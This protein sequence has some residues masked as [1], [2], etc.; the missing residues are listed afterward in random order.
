MKR[1]FLITNDVGLAL[2]KLGFILEEAQSEDPNMLCDY[3]AELLDIA[4]H[5]QQA[6]DN[7]V[8]EEDFDNV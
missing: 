1:K 4:D 8:F 5:L 3:H 6:L 2:D 7:L